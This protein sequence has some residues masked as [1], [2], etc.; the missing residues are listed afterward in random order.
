[1]NFT[2]PGL[3][4]P[5]HLPK[6]AQVH[7]H[8]IGNV[9]LPY[10]PLTPSSPSA[11]NLSKH[12]RL[13]PMSQLFTSDDQ[14]PGVSALASV[15]PVSSQGLFPLRLTGWISLLFKGLSRVFSS[16]TVQKHQFFG[17]PPS[18]QSNSHNRT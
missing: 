16:T 3:S 9:I 1:M 17:T 7:A 8:C 2:M 11:L 6:F 5:H 10:H 15:L 14:N 18:L 4:V 13:F 12:Q